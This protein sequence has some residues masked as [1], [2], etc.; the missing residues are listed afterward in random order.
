M[1]ERKQLLEWQN[2]GIISWY[3]MDW[4]SCSL[5]F[6]KCV[7]IQP[8]NLAVCLWKHSRSLK[9]QV[10]IYIIITRLN[11]GKG[12]MSERVEMYILSIPSISY[13]LRYILLS[14]HLCSA[15]W[16]YKELHCNSSIMRMVYFLRNFFQF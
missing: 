16:H 4:R 5:Y 13:I 2:G 15:P 7:I 12:W 9:C 14:H 3:N 10:R 1:A 6:Y 8:K 11:L